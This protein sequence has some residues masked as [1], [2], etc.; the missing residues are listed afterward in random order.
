LQKRDETLRPT[1]APHN[2]SSPTQREQHAPGY[3]Y[4]LNELPVGM[5]L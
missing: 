3:D 1:S 5:H 2:H 4:H